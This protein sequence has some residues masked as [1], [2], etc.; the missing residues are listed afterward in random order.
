MHPVTLHAADKM[1]KNSIIGGLLTMFYEISLMVT[2]AAFAWISSIL[3]FVRLRKH[4]R[5][6][7]AFRDLA[8]RAPIIY[9][10]LDI[11]GKLIIPCVMSIVFTRALFPR[12]PSLTSKMVSYA[13]DI[14][15]ILILCIIGFR[16]LLSRARSELTS[17]SEPE[18]QSDPTASSEPRMAPKSGDQGPPNLGA[19]TTHQT[20]SN[21]KGNGPEGGSK[22]AYAP[23][24]SGFQIFRLGIWATTSILWIFFPY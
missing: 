8:E 4:E 9:R 3:L 5:I 19:T 10:V 22:Y 16:L 14:V 1:L 20:F 7:K 2:L 12:D 21:D 11:F 23:V 17:P 18:I 6:E 13:I 15:V 24:G